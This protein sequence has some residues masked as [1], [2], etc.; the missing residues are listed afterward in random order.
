MLTPLLT[1]ADPAETSEGSI[2]PLGLYSIADALA[3]RLV[4]GVRERQKHP[5]FLTA[6]AVGLAICSQFEDEGPAAEGKSEPWQVFEW[7][8]VE[9]LMC[10]ISHNFSIIG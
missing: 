8:Q 10:T 1:E 3:T 5:R 6:I 9:G 7:Y 4:P 2:D